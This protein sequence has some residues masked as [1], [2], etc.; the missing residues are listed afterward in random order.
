M[1]HCF[2]LAAIGLL[3]VAL[4]ASAGG[5]TGQYVECRTCDVW[6]GPCFANAEMT[7]GKNAVMGWKVE[8]GTLDGAKLDG[9]SVVAIIA[10]SDTLGLEQ[11]GASKALL[12][13]DEK[14]T[15]V[16]RE[17]LVKLARQQGGELLKNVIKVESAPISID[18]C[19]CKEDGCA[20]LSAGGA[21]IETRCLDSHHDKKCGNEYAFYPPLVKNVSA[22]AAV[23][24]EHGY[25]G[26][27]LKYTWKES[28][29]RGAYVGT[30]EVK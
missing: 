10:S 30:F 22:T 18:A 9:L 12:I 27:G 15:A 7:T 13:V 19:L 28:E 17:A 1:K 14:A 6:T 4:P 5:I 16:Q 25:S 8:T 26:K 2:T 21:K 3:V 24:V 29:R 20:K 11:T 23:A